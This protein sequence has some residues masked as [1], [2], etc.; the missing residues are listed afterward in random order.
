V[1]NVGWRQ[2][3]QTYDSVSGKSSF[4]VDGLQTYYSYLWDIRRI[5]G[6]Q[7][8]TAGT[9]NWDSNSHILNGSYDG[10]KF[11]KATAFVYLLDFADSPAAFNSATYGFRLN[12]STDLSDDWKVGYQGSYAYQTDFGKNPVSYGANYVM[13]DADLGYKKLGALGAGFEMLGSDGGMAR[14]V[15]PLAT[16]HKFNGWADVFLDNG[17]TAGLR[18]FYAYVS[19]KLPWKLSGKLVYHHFR[20]DATNSA[21]G[22]EFDAV[23]KRPITKYLS[24]LTK[25]AYFDATDGSPRPN[26]FRWWLDVT[27][28]F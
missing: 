26:V 27:L 14:F 15:T 10:F 6:G 9:K 25:V 13:V 12:G 18:D 7:G 16:L 28:K 1:G 8:S 2:N 4:N 17:G 20:D 19:P 23:L 5:F 3:E 11:L 24:V 21:L 22:N